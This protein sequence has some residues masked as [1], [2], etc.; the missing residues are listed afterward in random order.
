MKKWIVTLLTILIVGMAGIITIYLTTGISRA[1]V[2]AEESFQAGEITRIQVAATSMNVTVKS[3]SSDQIEATVK[4]DVL[5]KD[6]DEQLF[7]IEKTDDMILITQ[8]E[9]TLGFLPW[10]TVKN[11]QVTVSVPEKSYD[12]VSIETTSGDIVLDH[13]ET[14]SV[15]IASTSGDVDLTGNKITDSLMIEATSGDIQAE[16]NTI[17]S[18]SI[19]TTS[20]T[21][22]N[23]QAEGSRFE[24][25]A[26]S[27][28]VVLSHSDEVEE[29]NIQT[30]SGDVSTEYEMPLEQFE[31]DFQSSSGDAA[32]HA[33]DMLFEEKSEHRIRGFI[34]ENPVHILK[35]RTDS[36]D[37]ILNGR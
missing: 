22:T 17:D 11:L 28:D 25:E 32:V 6:Q 36:G 5:E 15:Q 16:K 2:I 31:A 26:T 19:K 14:V 33:E 9:K 20:G 13:V 7:Q 29:V 21:I 18:A 8:K 3:Q 24:Y 4:G 23:Q 1:S 35:V 37:F 30:T 27:G 10:D 34:G 12:K